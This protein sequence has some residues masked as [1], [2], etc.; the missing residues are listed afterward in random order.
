MTVARV[1]VA[2]QNWPGAPGVTVFYADTTGMQTTVDGLRAFFNSC[3]AL[4]PSGMTITVPGTGDNIDEATGALVGTWAVGTPPV[5]V[6]ATGAGAY[7]GNAGA[8]VHWLTASVINGRRLRGRTFLVPLIATAYDT[9]GSIVASALTTLNNAATTLLAGAGTNLK[10]WHR[11]DPPA[12][13]SVA[14]WNGYRIPDL[15]VSLR[16]RRI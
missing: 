1:N 6:T 7:A 16:S 11:P 13:G 15:A 2:W 14:A 8:V 10:I 3:A 12:A 9:S 5:V 4:L